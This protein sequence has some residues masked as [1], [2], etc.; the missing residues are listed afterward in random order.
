M[1]ENVNFYQRH[2]FLSFIQDAYMNKSTI[3]YKQRTTRF[4]SYSEQAVAWRLDEK[5]ESRTSSVSGCLVSQISP[6]HSA[7]VDSSTA[8]RES[9]YS[10]CTVFP[11]PVN[12]HSRSLPLPPFML[13]QW[14]THIPI[15]LL[16]TYCRTRCTASPVSASAAAKEPLTLGSAF[17]CNSS[18]RLDQTSHLMRPRDR[19]CVD[20]CKVTENTTVW[21]GVFILLCATPS[22][23]IVHYHTEPVIYQRRNDGD[24]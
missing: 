15:P 24:V 18:K 22:S 12:T 14:M 11:S 19:V 17:Y 23:H 20:I 4:F 2:I 7:V 8:N 10:L 1:I 6:A 3:L 21:R 13:M 9:S 5:W 16:S